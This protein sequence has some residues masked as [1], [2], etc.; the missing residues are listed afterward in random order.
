MHH[1][2]RKKQINTPVVLSKHSDTLIRG[3]HAVIL[4]HLSPVYL[5]LLL[6][7]KQ[8]NQP[9]A[10]LTE[11]RE[12]EEFQLIIRNKLITINQFNS[13][14]SGQQIVQRIEEVAKLSFYS[15]HQETEC[16]TSKRGSYHVWYILCYCHVNLMFVLSSLCFQLWRRSNRSFNH[17]TQILIS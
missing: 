5:L 17:V 4:Y 16:V 12:T 6:Y 14:L 1:G 10:L 13:L 15:P 7:C 3:N 8:N 9:I 11:V 2:A